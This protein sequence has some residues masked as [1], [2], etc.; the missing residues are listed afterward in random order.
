VAVNSYGFLNTSIPIV[1][2]HASYHTAEDAELLR[3]T[4]QYVAITPESEM[5]YGHDHQWSHVIQDQASLGI[6]T[7]FTFS[8]DIVT[9][10]R[11]WMKE[12]RLLQYRHAQ[13]NREVARN[14]P[15]S[16]NQAFLLATRSGGLALRR[17]DIGVLREGAKADIV[18]FDGD[19]PNMLGWFD[20][21][22]AIILHSNIGDIRHV[23]VNGQFKKR[24]GQ[25]YDT[26][27]SD[28]KQKFLDSANRIQNIWLNTPP[29]PLEGIYPFT[30]YSSIPYISY[31]EAPT[32]DVIRG[33][34]NGY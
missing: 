26:K 4:N 21:V 25:L 14:N 34:H 12:T 33:P 5:L 16:V 23:M 3:S 27:W 19:T 20:P 13:E 22:A 29:T 6:D 9:Q 28:I 11:I 8:T 24:D 17:P 1:F 30:S 31:D 18:V 2:S 7:H 32:E 15:M 10:A